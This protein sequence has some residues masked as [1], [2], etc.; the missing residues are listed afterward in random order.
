MYPNDKDFF[1]IPAP[2]V[3]SEDNIIVLPPHCVLPFPFDTT[4]KGT[5]MDLTD[6][7]TFSKYKQFPPRDVLRYQGINPVVCCPPLDVALSPDE[8]ES[9]TDSAD[10][11]PT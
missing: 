9:A 7:G 4:S 6:C 5:E 2:V 3:P 8:F 1:Y 10:S 11:G